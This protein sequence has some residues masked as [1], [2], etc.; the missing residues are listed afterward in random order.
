MGKEL[1]L[2]DEHGL[3]PQMMIAQGLTQIMNLATREAEHMTNLSEARSKK[4]T[5]F[6]ELCE[7]NGMGEKDFIKHVTDGI[8]MCKQRGD[9]RALPKMLK[10]WTDLMYT[11]S[12]EMG[13]IFSQLTVAF[14]QINNNAPNQDEIEGPSRELDA[15]KDDLKRLKLEHGE[16]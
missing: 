9:T 7:E 15:L 2:R 16:S 5:K 14:Q 12:F 8:E 1:S 3:R 6:L 13:K 11:N 4:I 10:I